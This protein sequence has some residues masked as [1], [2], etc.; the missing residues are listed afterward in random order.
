MAIQPRPQAPPPADGFR[1]SKQQ[2]RLQAL[3]GSMRVEWVTYLIIAA[4]V[5]VFVAMVAGGASLLLPEGSIVVAWGGNS[6]LH[7]AAGQWWRLFSSVFLHFGILHL[8][9]NMYVL[10]SAGPTAERLF[11]HAGFLVA[12]AFAGF[13]GSLASYL[14][15]GAT[16]YVAA[17][18]SGAIF[19]VV[20]LLLAFVL[21]RRQLM[22]QGVWL[23]LRTSLIGFI[24]IN[25]A[26]GFSLGFIDQ[27][28]HLGGLAGGFLAGLIF[29]PNVDD[30]TMRVVRPWY[31]YPIPVLITAAVCAYLAYGGLPFSL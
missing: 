1:S 14:W 4:N 10:R 21:R 29:V 15:R 18:A 20:G 6:G 26:L 31:L 9:V 5:A 2:E 11:G 24:L 22:P 7:V 25:V 16:N 30:R 12:Y 17:G 28:G 23:Q 27:A 3:I 13:T 8:G 19:G